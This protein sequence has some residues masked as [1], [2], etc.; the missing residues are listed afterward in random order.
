VGAALI[1]FAVAVLRPLLVRVLKWRSDA[2]RGFEVP[3]AWLTFLQRQIPAAT[4]L[5]WDQRTR[6]L[7]AAHELM[8]GRHWEGCSGLVLTEDMRLAIAAQACLLILERP[9]EPFPSL[10]TILVY[11]ETFVPRRFRDLRKWKQP[12]YDADRESPELG[13]AVHGETIVLAWDAVLRGAANAEDGLNVVLHEFAHQLAMEHHLISDWDESHRPDVPD[14]EAWQQVMRASYEQLCGAFARGENPALDEYGTTDPDEFFA[15][16]T[17]VFFER[18]RA[19]R[20]EYPEL[21]RML[22]TFYRQNPA[23]RLRD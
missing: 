4:G 9:G 1:A 7:R 14:P 17:E 6:L 12:C 15:V 16:A 19:L 3:A 10:R 20:D 2:N 22:Q 13:E 5:S 8:T 11:P 18:P 21:Y 23:Q